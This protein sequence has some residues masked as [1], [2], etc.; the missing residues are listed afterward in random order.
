[1]AEQEEV[2]LTVKQIAKRMSVD[3]KTVRNWI[4]KQDL[5]A[6]NVGGRRPEY[7]IKPSDFE[8]FLNLRRAGN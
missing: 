2:M 4:T 3:E 5:K 1:M 7:R 8:E 6:F